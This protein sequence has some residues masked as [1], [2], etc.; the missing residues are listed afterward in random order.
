MCSFRI[1][2]LLVTPHIHL[3]ILISF[4]SS[5]AS[6][7]PVVA[8]VTAPYKLQQSWSDHSEFCKPFPSVY[9]NHIIIIYIICNLCNTKCMST[10]TWQLAVTRVSG[11]SP[12]PLLSACLA[13]WPR[14]GM[15]EP[16]RAHHNS[17]KIELNEVVQVSKYT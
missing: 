7:P 9:R 11:P 4:T 17:E 13:V 5:R 1:L 10:N 14:A 12:C 8:Q 2:S 3:S 6:R 16:V 15:S